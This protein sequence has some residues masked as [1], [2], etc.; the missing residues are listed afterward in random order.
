[1]HVA[2]SDNTMQ[3][4][5]I[6]SYLLDNKILSCSA[7]DTVMKYLLDSLFIVVLQLVLGQRASFV[8]GNKVKHSGQ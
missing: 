8:L 3:F 7:M 6:L 4:V 5:F 1:M 2:I